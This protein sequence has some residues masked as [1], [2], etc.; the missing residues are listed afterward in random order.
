MSQALYFFS[1][2]FLSPLL[3]SFRFSRHFVVDIFFSP[4]LGFI[5]LFF[6]G[7][8]K[9][10][11]FSS[12][13][14]VPANFLVSSCTLDGRSS[15]KRVTFVEKK[16]LWREILNHVTRVVGTKRTGRNFQCS[17]RHLIGR[18]VNNTRNVLRSLENVLSFF[19]VRLKKKTPPFSLILARSLG[20]N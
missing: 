6:Y 19:L 8:R 13:F 3:E 14:C 12:T 1:L 16:S 4:A 11:R 9:L 2:F 7:R 10:A 17:L 5:C 20:M 15:N 18:I